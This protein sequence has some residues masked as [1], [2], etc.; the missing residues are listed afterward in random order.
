MSYAL[1]KKVLTPKGKR[2]LK[3]F[4]LS[5]KDL[6]LIFDTADSLIGAEDTWLLHNCGA[7]E[8][9]AD[10]ITL[11]VLLGTMIG[12]ASGVD[13]V[14]CAT[15]FIATFNSSQENEMK[16]FKRAGFRGHKKGVLNRNSGSTIYGMV[17]MLNPEYVYQWYQ[18][19]D[20]EDD[21]DV[22]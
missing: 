11:P 5:D 20:A 18:W 13:G 16:V 8:I 12:Y 7:V 2:W 21:G 22:W 3:R 10:S 1:F 15:L 17:G 6:R 4:K 19:H 14:G 9:R